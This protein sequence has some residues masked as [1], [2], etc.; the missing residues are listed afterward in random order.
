M[1][2]DDALEIIE[3]EGEYAYGYNVT[4]KRV[5]VPLNSPYQGKFIADLNLKYLSKEDVKNYAEDGEFT[6]WE[7][8]VQYIKGETFKY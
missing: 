4:K 7:F 5:I 1:T 6:I 8:L 2:Y 3:R